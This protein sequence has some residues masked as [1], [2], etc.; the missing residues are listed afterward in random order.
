MPP[1]LPFVT[2]RALAAFT[3]AT[4]MPLHPAAHERHDSM[5][6]PL[7]RGCGCHGPLHE[8]GVCAGGSLLGPRAPCSSTRTTSSTHQ[9]SHSRRCRNIVCVKGRAPT[10]SRHDPPIVFAGNTMASHCGGGVSGT[11]RDAFVSMLWR[12]LTRTWNAGPAPSL[13]TCTSAGEAFGRQHILH[14]AAERL[15]AARA[16]PEGHG[17][18]VGVELP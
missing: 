15:V 10:S 9:Q 11:G 3:R 6:Q 7:C 18:G 14:G 1:T 2:E 8:R 12:L 5:A 16:V 13:P 4:F 17:W